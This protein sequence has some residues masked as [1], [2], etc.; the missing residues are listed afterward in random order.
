M[1]V[2]LS[3]SPWVTNLCFDTHHNID[4][5]VAEEVVC[6]LLG[7]W[8]IVPQLVDAYRPNQLVLLS[9]WQRNLP[10]QLMRMSSGLSANFSA[11]ALMDSSSVLSA[12]RAYT[13][14]AL[15]CKDLSDIARHGVGHPCEFLTSDTDSFS[16]VCGL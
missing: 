14:L 9:L 1:R 16:Q 13:L 2:E 8:L 4:L 10:A 15:S 7:E 11:T 5:E 12:S 6:G 3:A